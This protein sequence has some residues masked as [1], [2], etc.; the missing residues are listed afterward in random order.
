[1]QNFVSGSRITDFISSEQ[2]TKPPHWVTGGTLSIIPLLNARGGSPHE[3]L[4][5]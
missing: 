2:I 1:M 4:P 3:E 5:L